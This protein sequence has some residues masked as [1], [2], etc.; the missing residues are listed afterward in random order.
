MSDKKE[1]QIRIQADKNGNSAVFLY[2]KT[3]KGTQQIPDADV[4]EWQQY[5]EKDCEYT[6]NG[7]QLVITID[8]KIIKNSVK[9]GNAPVMP[10]SSKKIQGGGYSTKDK[11]VKSHDEGLYKAK[12]A[13]TVSI[14]KIDT[15]Y[16]PADVRQINMSSNEIDNFALRLN[17]LAI[18]DGNGKFILS[19]KGQISVQENFKKNEA[20]FRRL[21]KQQKEVAENLFPKTCVKKFS[22]K[23]RL[24]VGLGGASVYETSMTLHHVYGFP[25]IPASS[26]KGV[27]RSYITLKCFGDEEKTALKDKDFVEIFGSSAAE[28]I[29]ENNVGIGAITFF[30]AF[31]VSA[32]SVEPDIMNV[33][34][35]DYYNN[36]GAPTDTQDPL[37]VSFLTV[38]KNTPFQFIIGAKKHNLMF[39]GKQLGDWLREALSEHGIGAKT[40][41]GYGYMQE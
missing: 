35:R 38:K 6:K 36:T 30:D 11:L 39:Q 19:E 2:R 4:N 3:D 34:Y 25:Y 27:L 10:E 5:N 29:G 23:W 28:K 24:A 1:G 7:K 26:I 12:A 33:H 40:A 16:L 9:D 31:P 32:P 13:P 22:T 20:L 15:R 14:S 21:I 37:P 8:G 18:T 17:K 41:V